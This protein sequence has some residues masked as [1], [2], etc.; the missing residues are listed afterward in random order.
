MQS[1][2]LEKT[3]DEALDASRLKSEFLAN[4]SHEIRTPMNGI[5]GMTG[6]VLDT[7][8]TAEQSEYLDMVKISA[9][10][11]LRLLNDILDSSKIESGK[12]ELDPENFSLRE[13]LDAALRPMAV[14][15]AERGLALRTEIDPDVPDGLYADA[16]RLQQVLV[17]LAGNAIKFTQKGTV[18]VKAGVESIR[19]E[20]VILRF[21]VCDT[22]IG[23]PKDKLEL[24]F[25]PFQQADGSTT[26][27]YGGTGLGLSICSNLV[28]LMGGQFEVES[29]EGR[30]SVFS[31]TI[32]FGPGSAV[33][34]RPSE[35]QRSIEPPSTQPR[36]LSILLAEDY[37]VNRRLALRLLQKQ[38]HQVTCARD[39]AE[40]LTLLDQGRFDLVLMD[41]E[42]PNLNG[43][44]AS[45][46]IR[47]REKTGG[48]H[49]PIVAHDR[50]RDEGRRRDLSRVRHGRLPQQA[51]P[52]GRSGQRDPRR[53]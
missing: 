8:L 31:F 44:E 14:A 22:G 47:Q 32:A 15:A 43:L 29:E 48:G 13:L 4:M 19:G 39:G 38:G 23:I 36:S 37:A 28:A 3:R 9:D 34:H 16:G 5:I 21:S 2:E 6:L 46:A 33:P 53:A 41:V 35:P 25:E 30:G 52:P 11:L 7:Q 27:R 24:I 17:N 12:V 20:L 18:T 45:A 1:K 40:A 50:T 26:R 10:S 51:D 42:M 49:I